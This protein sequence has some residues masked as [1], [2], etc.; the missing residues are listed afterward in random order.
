MP[1]KKI[2]AQSAHSSSKN[3]LADKQT[4]ELK[5]GREYGQ[6][7]V[8]E[9]EYATGKVRVTVIWDAWARAPLEDHSTTILQAYE[10][11]NSR[12][13]EHPGFRERERGL[14]DRIRGRN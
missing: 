1:R 11:A 6:P 14:R 7:L 3:R 4:D 2:G 9:H 13:S 12:L 10:K 5:S 8:F